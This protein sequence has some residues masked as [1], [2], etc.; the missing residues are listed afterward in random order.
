M[1]EELR[2]AA[3]D[4]KP[5]LRAESAQFPIVFRIF[6]SAERHAGHQ[7][8]LMVQAYGIRGLQIGTLDMVLVE[9][10]LLRFL[11]DLL[12][13]AFARRAPAFLFLEKGP[14]TILDVLFC[15]LELQVAPREIGIPLML[16]DVK[17]EHALRFRQQRLSLMARAAA[18]VILE[19]GGQFAMPELAVEFDAEAMVGKVYVDFHT[20]E[21]VSVGRLDVGDAKIVLEPTHYLLL[22]GGAV[23]V[24]V[25]IILEIEFLYLPSCC[26]VRDTKIFK[27]LRQSGF[28]TILML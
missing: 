10:R 16:E 22:E 25:D 19:L 11:R 3:L 12:D 1:G 21:D 15:V 14:Q 26:P 28:I 13:H 5:M 4:A 18:S 27:N 23:G 24:D 9:E 7:I 8:V 2:R 17:Q 20:I 6:R